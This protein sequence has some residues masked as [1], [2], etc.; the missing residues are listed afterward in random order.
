MP[1]CGSGPLLDRMES[2]KPAWT[3]ALRVM[4]AM[5]TFETF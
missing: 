3:R 5:A 4:D 2:S 1:E